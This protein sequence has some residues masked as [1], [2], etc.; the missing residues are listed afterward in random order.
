LLLDAFRFTATTRRITRLQVE[1]TR[2]LP[3]FGE[4]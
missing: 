4:P 1:L 2:S 3:L